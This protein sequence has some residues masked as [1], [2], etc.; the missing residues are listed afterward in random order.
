MPNRLAEAR[1]PYLLQHAH[2]P[3]DWY[4]WGD[5][6]FAK[7]KAEGKPVFLSIGYSSCHWCH[8]M[9]HESFEDEEVARILNRSYVSVK[10]DREERPDVDEAYMTAVQMQ[11]GRG[12]WPV[13]VF[14]TPDREP[15]L[16]GTYFP[17]L[18]RA[19]APGFLSILL[20]IERQW[21]TKRADIEGAAKEFA[22]QLSQVLTRGAPK[23]FSTLDWGVV[24]SAIQAL[25]ADFDSEHGGFSKS[26]KFPPHSSLELLLW[27][28]TT[29]PI[30]R[31][32]RAEALSMAALTLKKM[33]LGG[34]HDQVGGGFHRYST[35]ERWLLPH[36]EKMLYDNALLLGNY[37][38][39]AELIQSFDPGLSSLLA[40]AADGI[41]RWMAEDMRGPDGL[42]YSALDA[43]TDGEEGLTY[44][45]S[46]D[47]IRRALGASADRFLEAFNF[48]PDGNFR[49][50]AT[51]KKTGKNIPHLRD[52][53]GEEFVEELETL[54]ELRRR[55]PQPG[56]DNK[57]LVSWN[58]LA[59]AG[60]AEAG[61]IGLA[62]AAARAERHAAR[63]HGRLPHQ[64]VGGAP[65]GDAF[66]D[67]V[68]ALAL[69]L[70]RL[71]EVTGHEEFA[72]EARRLADQM[73]AEFFDDEDGGFFYTSGRHETLFGRTKPAFDQ[74]I[75]SGNAM[76]VRCLVALGEF[77]RA[78]RSIE[79]F[80]GW[81][82]RA[83]QATEALLLAAGELLEAVE[84]M[85]RPEPGRPNLLAADVEPGATESEA[86][87]RPSPTPAKVEKKQVRVSVESQTLAADESGRARGTLHIEIPPGLH[88]NGP[89]PP[90]R[91]L[92][93]TEVRFEGIPGNVSWP[94]ATD[95]GYFG[96]VRVPF[97]VRAEAGEVREF[98][99]LVRFQACTDTSCLEPEEKT[100][101]MAVRPV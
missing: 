1:S 51:G 84:S 65:D 46:E 43:D 39:S 7:A 3:V 92:T 73:I 20:S 61:E 42:F 9:A 8:V 90:M 94:E 34:I 72:H 96:T 97:E 26:P 36:F 28:A 41:V 19:Q 24:E 13:S 22:S 75:P 49:D 27:A 59:I 86:P 58:G 18:D 38:R 35:D 89:N 14:L 11:S 10:V 100:F 29:Q 25:K 77:D 70:I 82:E 80:F 40:R 63:A 30:G 56:V 71:F 87:A 74:P 67:D 81:L 62:V 50:E 57:A 47:E 55:R 79:T 15:F 6:A 91:W 32:R 69:G 37:A 12:G 53:R 64:V 23:T 45:W 60:L 68:S 95:M 99:V 48:E 5:E 93:A 54:R 76:A 2:N 88:I 66:L 31:D 85:S 83:P 33:A 16:A 21:K 101:A 4:P 78:R 17:K 98:Q 52:D 44:V